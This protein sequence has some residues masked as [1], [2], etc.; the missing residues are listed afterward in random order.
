[1]LSNYKCMRFGK[2]RKI[3]FLGSPQSDYNNLIL[4]ENESECARLFVKHM[5]G[6]LAG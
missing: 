4:S 1:M 5:K 2:L 3:E 6:L